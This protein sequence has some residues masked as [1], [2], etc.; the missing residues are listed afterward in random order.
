MMVFSRLLCGTLLVVLICG[1]EEGSPPGNDG[2]PGDGVS[3]GDVLTEGGADVSAPADSSC[4]PGDSQPCY[5]GPSG[6]NGVGVCT[7]GTRTCSAGKWG[8]CAGDTTP[9]VETCDGKDNDCDGST[10]ENLAPLVCYTGKAGT[11]GIGVCKAGS[12]KCSGGHW[13]AC[14]GEMTPTKETCDGKDNDCDGSTDEELTQTCYTGK[15]GTSGKGPCKVGSSVCVGGSLSSCAGEVVPAKEI[16]DG[17]DNDC[18]GSTDEVWPNCGASAWTSEYRCN[19]SL[20]ERKYNNRGCSKAGACFVLPTWK[21][22]KDCGASSCA[23]WSAWYISGA[24]LERKRTCTTRGCSSNACFKTTKVQVE[25]KADPNVVNHGSLIFIKTR[26]GRCFSAPYGSN[27]LKAS[28]SCSAGSASDEVFSIVKPSGTGPL[29][30]GDKVFLKIN[31][32]GLCLTAPYG[33]GCVCPNKSKSCHPDPKIS[34]EQ[35]T[36]VRQAGTG[37]L[38][39]KD[40]VY[41]KTRVGYYFSSPHGNNAVCTKNSAHPVWGV[42]DE[43]FEMVKK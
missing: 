32:T 21:T 34:D 13:S 37:W 23:A 40:H 20:R 28:T 19:G 30:H 24:K 4:S 16:C 33:K 42:S 25:T 1:C 15:L 22:H 27:C 35:F 41:F 38:R 14:A 3:V 8:P 39:S 36:V 9:T 18:D 12:Q 6:T 10:D 7:A 5:S 11:N 31:Y 26:T 2:S 43:L 29:Q 17:K